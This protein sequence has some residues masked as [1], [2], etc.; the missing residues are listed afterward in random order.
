MIAL[1]EADSPTVGYVPSGRRLSRWARRDA[2]RSAKAVRS[3]TASVRAAASAQAPA[4]S[5]VPERIERS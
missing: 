5:G 2:A 1:D 3:E 4:T